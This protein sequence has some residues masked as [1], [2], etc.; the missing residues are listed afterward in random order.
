MEIEGPVSARLMAGLVEYQRVFAEWFPERFHPI[1]ILAKGGRAVVARDAPER[2][3]GVRLGPR[4]ACAF[5]GGVD[6]YHALLEH[7]GADAL[8]IAGFDTPVN[9]RESLADMRTRLAIAAGKLGRRLIAVET[10]AREWLDTVDWTNAHGPLLAAAA[11]FFEGEWN[12]F[13]VPS[14]YRPGTSPRWGTHPALDPLLSTESLRFTHESTPHSR[15]D[16]LARL[17]A[18]PAAHESLRVC[19]RQ[20]LGLRNCGEC[21]KCVRTMIGL[22]VL[23]VLPRFTTFPARLA[24]ARVSGLTLRNHQ[25]RL[26]AR[27]MA[28]GALRRGRLGWTLAIGEAFVRRAIRRTLS[29]VLGRIRNKV[30]FGA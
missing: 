7:P 22:D 2:P 5:S 25:A 6:S 12:E 19:W 14:S 18:E 10:N 27:E 24:R 3:G 9:L 30:R 4:Q 23:G 1:Q 13:I 28:W 11:L 8:W 20:D 21:E 15:L 16:K 17:V 26:F 29:S